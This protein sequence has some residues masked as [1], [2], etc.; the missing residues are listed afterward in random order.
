MRRYLVI[1]ALLAVLGTACSGAGED[2]KDAAGSAGKAA[3]KAGEAVAECVPG[4]PVTIVAKDLKFDSKCI[5]I[6]ADEAAMIT[7]NNQDTQPHNLSVYADKGGE[8]KFDGSAQ[9]TAAGASGQYNVPALSAGTYYFQ[10]DIHPD[11]NGAF[12]TAA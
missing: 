10:C 4:G 5:A 2:A 11:M 8:K 1:A 9:I 12:I 7:M 6:E 3:G